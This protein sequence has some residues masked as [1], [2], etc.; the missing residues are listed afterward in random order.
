MQSTRYDKEGAGAQIIDELLHVGE[1]EGES[2]FWFCFGGR[3]LASRKGSHDLI[4][5]RKSDSY[6]LTNA[7][8]L[9]WILHTVM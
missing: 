5:D 6:F 1:R 4:W 2:V 9:G 8:N 7:G 3:W